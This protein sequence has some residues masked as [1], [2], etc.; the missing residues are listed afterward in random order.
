MRGGCA[1]TKPCASQVRWLAKHYP[2]CDAYTQFAYPLWWSNGAYFDF[3]APSFELT[4][5]H[6]QTGLGRGGQARAIPSPH[7]TT[8]HVSGAGHAFVRSCSSFC[9][10]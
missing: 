8:S 9:V 10:W 4:L 7:T 5:P 2:P 1:A 6:P 3:A